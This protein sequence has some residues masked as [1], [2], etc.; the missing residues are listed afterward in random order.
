M[1]QQA[2]LILMK[3]DNEE[4]ERRVEILEKRLTNMMNDFKNSQSEN[5]TLLADCNALKAEAELQVNEINDLQLLTDKQVMKIAEL[6]SKLN[7]LETLRTQ[8]AM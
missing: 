7:D 4:K 2:A 5:A 8:L 3:H 6:Q 1:E